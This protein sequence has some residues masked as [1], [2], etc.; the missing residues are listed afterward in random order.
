MNS[1]QA[2]HFVD[3]DLLNAANP[4]TFN[5][6]GAGGTG[7]HMLAALVRMNHTLLALDH[8]G[9]QVNLFDDDIV[10]EFNPGRQVFSPSE[11]NLCKSVAL[12]NRVNRE[13]GTNWKAIPRKFN[14]ETVDLY[15]EHSSASFYISC[16]DKIA[17]RFE[18]AEI[19]TKMKSEFRNTRDQ[20]LYWLDCGNGVSTGQVVLSTVGEIK[21]PASKQFKAVG[22]LPFVTT[23]FKYLLD[24]VDEVDI[25]S[26]SAAESLEKQDLFI[27]PNIANVGATLIWRMFRKGMT[28]I[29]GAFLNLDTLVMQPIYV[30]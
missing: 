15:P 13:L 10:N 21:Q 2:I 26:C 3:T 6:I 22:H 29:R 24:K 20:P 8:P 5:L 27:N 28:P 30:S 9:I 18:I 14:H 16:V 1:K 19:I 23:E 25:P 7:G 17:A 12:I 4:I 11:H